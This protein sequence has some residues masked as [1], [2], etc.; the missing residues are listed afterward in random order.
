MKHNINEIIISSDSIKDMIFTI[1]GKQVLV[2]RDLA[3]LY[4]VETKVL[5]QAVKRN[6]ERF[7]DDFR[8]QLSDE[9]KN[10]LVTNCDRFKNLKHSTSNPYVFTELGVSMLSAVLKSQVAINISINIIRAFVDMRKFLISNASIF[11]RLEKT[12]QKLIK[13]DKNFQKIFELLEQD[14]I[15]SQGIFYDGQIYDA[16]VF[17]NT[18]L[19][20]AKKDVILI[21]NYID[22]TV[23]T[24]FSK[25]HKLNFTLITK[26][27]SKKQ[28]LDI[29]KYNSQYRNLK[30]QISSKF[31]DRFLVI[32]D[33]TYHIG[34]SLKDLGKKVFAF[35]NIKLDK[36][37]LELGY[38][39]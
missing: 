29:D 39:L 25:Y 11:E 34:A 12:E 13:H 10:E 31:H 4:Q 36:K 30:I 8:F 3:I 23:L 37:I 20:K 17:V 1:R 2:D 6:I 24:L 28:K 26:S 15:P 16:Y 33:T 19:K 14:D 27:V 32:D 35:S 22:D 38:E 21:D 9:E 7:P 5:N 18:L